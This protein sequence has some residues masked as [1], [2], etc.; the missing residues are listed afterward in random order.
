[1]ATAVQP[2]STE[3]QAPN[4]RT[5]LAFV[6]V[7]GALFVL[8]GI[9]V[10][11]Y[12]VPQLWKDTVTPALGQGASFVDVTLRLL[13][14]LAVAAAIIWL[15]T[16]LAG[17]NPPKGLRGGIFLVIAT[18]VTI[19]FLT[20]AV[21]LN[22]A[23]LQIASVVTGGVLAVLLFFGYRFL[24]SQRGVQYMHALEEQG[25]FSAFSHKRSQGV[26]ARRYT[27]LGILIVGWTGVWAIVSQEPFGRG[28]W[29][30]EVPFTDKTVTVLSDIEYTIPLL[31]AALTFW[32]A[33]RAVNL[34][35]FADFLIATE[36][37]MNKV[38]WSSK[39]RLLQDTIVVLVT[40]VLLTLFLLVVD[41]FWGWLLS[42][43][44]IGVL[45][46]RTHQSATIDPIQGKKVDW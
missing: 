14:Q 19:F 34:P 10:A 1:M 11:A 35:T 15:G 32:I 38:S 12:L 4:P 6:S 46:P 23:D 20:R 18:A 40:V 21:W 7:L 43:R 44:P 16:R 31:L 41:I 27:L 13:T 9:G 25:W 36:A 45:P 26:R 37:E 5:R 8:A 3:P 28:D 29:N 42:L 2:N 17:D 30:L 39:R 24:V 33:W 22:T